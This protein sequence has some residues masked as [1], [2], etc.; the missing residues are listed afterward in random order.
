MPILSPVC[1]VLWHMLDPCDADARPEP[2]APL[3]GRIFCLFQ[4]ILTRP[5]LRATKGASRPED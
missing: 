4:L 5:R 3:K 1:A 2:N